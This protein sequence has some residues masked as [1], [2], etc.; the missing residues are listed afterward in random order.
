METEIEI[1]DVKE[2]WDTRPCNIRHS[3]L[4]VGT[5]DYF[6]EVETRKYLVEPHI[7]NFADFEKY[8]GKKVLEIGCGIGTDAVNF[9]RAGA[10][11]TG[12]E[13]STETLK[14][15]KLRFSIYG[16]VGDFIEGNAENIAEILVNHKFDL[17][18]SFGVLHHTPNI[19]EALKQIRILC[20]ETT[21]FK[22]MVY[23]K[24]SWKNALIEIGLDQPEA[25]FGCPIANVY[26]REEIHQLLNNSGF[27]CIEITQSHIFPFKVEKYV[28][29]E[30]E[31]EE[32][33]K[34]MPKEMFS[35]LEG[36]LG[37]HLLVIA[38]PVF[39]K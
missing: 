25:Q 16:L 20:H 37:W 18:Y 8:K 2:Y 14:L 23:A 22:F 15:A 17:V 6:D 28:K 24:N 3:R 10:S 35:K 12:V 19:I 5:K 39:P 9:A 38:A 13:I 30:Y 32:W 4:E 1:S 11:Y 36:V 27:K 29:Y 21:E 33:F 26:S 34:A 7:L 31:Y